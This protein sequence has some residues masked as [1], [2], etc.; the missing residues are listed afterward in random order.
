MRTRR[1]SKLFFPLSRPRAAG[2][3]SLHLFLRR[4]HRG[5]GRLRFARPASF[6]SFPARRRS[7]PFFLPFLSTS[8]AERRAP[9]FLLLFGID[10]VAPFLSFSSYSVRRTTTALSFSFLA[11]GGKDRVYSPHLSLE[12]GRTNNAPLFLFF[13]AVIIKR[14]GKASL[15][16]GEVYPRREEGG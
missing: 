2:A 11:R 3:A 7:S 12:I 8:L 9:P 5:R 10:V 15:P 6:L 1:P 16:S 13:I 14:L 4:P